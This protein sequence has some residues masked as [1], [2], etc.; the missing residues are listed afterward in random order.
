MLTK[1]LKIPVA[2]IHLEVVFKPSSRAKRASLRL[3]PYANI[4]TV[5]HPL[6]IPYDRAVRFLKDNQA[7][8]EGALNRRG[9][10]VQ[11]QHGTTLPIFGQLKRVEFQRADKAGVSCQDDI[12]TITGFDD[13]V[14]AGLLKDWLRKQVYEM[15]TQQS[16]A[17]ASTLGQQIKGITL[18]EM[19][20]RWGSCSHRG[21]LCYNWRL[22]FAPY[23]ALIY[24]CAHEVAHMVEM[25]HSPAF[26][27]IVQGLFP[28][29]LQH[30]RWLKKNGSQLF[31]YG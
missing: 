25:N 20:S 23:E 6:H 16:H 10:Y 1:T 3:D 11:F 8:L 24:V 19:K 7:W 29:Y 13:I 5:T 12:I 18:K 4:V 22:I 17:F 21:Q 28:S 2:D 9:T 30:R 31:L 14:V 26:W 15:L 27:Q